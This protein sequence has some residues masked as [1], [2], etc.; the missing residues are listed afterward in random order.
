MAPL[1]LPGAH[2]SDF[3]G[4]SDAALTDEQICKREQAG[5]K[6]IP[7][8]TAGMVKSS[9]Y[10]VIRAGGPFEAEPRCPARTSSPAR[11]GSGTIHG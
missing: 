3:K 7:S 2:G 8:Q 4:V 10:D 1:T 9:A 5:V 11:S 6:L